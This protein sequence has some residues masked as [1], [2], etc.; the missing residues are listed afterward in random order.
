VFDRFYRVLGTGQSGSGLGLSIVQTIATRIGVRI[1]LDDATWSD[2]RGGL[3]VTLI[4]PPRDLPAGPAHHR[5]M[6][7][8]RA[9]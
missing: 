8:E 5:P 9:D 4:F 1:T 7:G 3:R 2:G 6:S